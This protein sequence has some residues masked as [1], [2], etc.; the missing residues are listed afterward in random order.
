MH[1]LVDRTNQLA[2]NL[3]LGGRSDQLDHI[4]NTSV[5]N[6]LVMARYGS[7]GLG[8]S[9]RYDVGWP[10]GKELGLESLD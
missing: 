9:G 1:E 7:H 10:A 5:R 6:C 4:S 8:P 2:H 3:G